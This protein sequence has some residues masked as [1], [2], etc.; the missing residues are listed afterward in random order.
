MTE[1]TERYLALLGVSIMILILLC[2]SLAFAHDHNRPDLNSWYPTLHSG[3]GPCCDGPGKDAQHLS[4][5]DWKRID[6]H[7]EVFLEGEWIVVPE[8]AIVNQPNLDGQAI[9][10]P[11]YQ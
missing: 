5:D 1:R 10:W 7:Y 3:K 2:A 4:V 8:E 6:G 9:V 11:M